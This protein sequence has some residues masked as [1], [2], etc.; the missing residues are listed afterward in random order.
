[1]VSRRLRRTT[2]ALRPGLNIAREHFQEQRLGVTLQLTKLQGRALYP[3]DR[4]ARSAGAR[5]S[6]RRSDC[7]HAARIAQ[8]GLR[9]PVMRRTKRHVRHDVGYVRRIARPLASSH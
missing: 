6:E 3:E 7:F 2:D 8:P 5:S 9:F 1:M 4:Q